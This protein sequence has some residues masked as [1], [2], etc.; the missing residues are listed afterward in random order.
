[1]IQSDT[2][3]RQSDHIPN[4]DTD[5]E[6]VIILPESL[7]VKTMDTELM[8]I[9]NIQTIDTELQEQISNAT[10][11]NNL[12][13]KALQALKEK[14]TPPIKSDLSDWK[15]KE[16]LLF[17]KDKCYVPPNNELRKNI[18]QR[19]HD[20]L[21]SG[22]PGH[23]KTLELVKRHYWWP[24]MYVFIKNYVAGCALCQQMKVNTHPTSPGLIPIKGTTTG[25][26]FSQVTM[27]FITDLPPSE[28]FDSLMVVVDHGSTKGVIS[29]PCNKTIDAME[30]AQLYFDNVYRRF[31]LPDSMLSDR[32]PQFASKV[33]Q[34]LGKL[35]GI[36][37]KMST[38]YHPQTDGETER[39]NQ[40]LEIYFRMF[41][42]NN[43]ETWKK[44][45]P[46]M[47]FCHNQRTHSTT[48][49]S[50]FY[51]MMGIEPRDVPLAF[52][53]TNIPSVEERLHNLKKVRD[54]AQ[55]AQELARQKV[56]G[57]G[58]RGFT[59]FKQGDMVWLEGTNL[60][61]GYASKK[62]APKREGPFKITEVLGPITYKLK[63]PDQWKI[64]LVFHASLLT[65]FRETE[66][67][68]PNYT[69]P[70]PDL[71]EDEEQYEIKAILAH[72]CQG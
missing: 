71:I 58:R 43:P 53:P 46:I 45:I 1:M 14:G 35:L 38:E 52:E 68:G 3:S 6:D 70:P 25:R 15:F 50:P 5:N 64:H 18:A 49:R 10:T 27:D 2:L 8:S 72:R 12:F 34:E 17:Y 4:E 67:H 51:L 11:H 48:Q 54:E 41:C 30:T 61:I 7:F 33:F 29:I 63:L 62:I 16:E 21:P 59:P 31:G 36:R 24:G 20:S 66:A 22:H 37:L 69:N 40:E 60:K 19:Y 13:A 44:Y 32:G 26:P 55:A 42:G 47:E 28:K 65:P 56:A 57:R 23:Q 39:V 9:L